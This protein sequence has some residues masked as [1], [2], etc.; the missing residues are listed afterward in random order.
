MIFPRH[1]IWPLTHAL[2]MWL[3]PEV[4]QTYIQLFLPHIN[5]LSAVVHDS[6]SYLTQ[7]NPCDHCPGVLDGTIGMTCANSK[8]R[9]YSAIFN[10]YQQIPSLVQQMKIYEGYINMCKTMRTHPGGIHVMCKLCNSYIF[11][12][13]IKFPSSV[14]QKKSKVFYFLFSVMVAILDV[15]SG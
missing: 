14:Q 11:D 1:T 5:N 9:I 13:F 12:H 10:E 6:F 7:R 8:K 2:G 3:I 15:V 4:S